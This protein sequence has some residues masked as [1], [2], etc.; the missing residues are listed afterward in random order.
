MEELSLSDTPIPE[1][2]KIRWPK[3]V[4]LLH[5]FEK[6]FA[7]NRPKSAIKNKESFE[8]DVLNLFFAETSKYDY[9]FDLQDCEGNEEL[10]KSRVAQILNKLLYPVDPIKPSQLHA[11]RISSA[12]TNVVFQ[13]TLD[14][15]PMWVPAVPRPPLI[16][17]VTTS[18]SFIPSSVLPENYILRVYGIGIDQVIDRNNEL[19]WLNVLGKLGI[20]ARVFGLFQNGRLEEYLCNRSL[21]KDD[22]RN[23]EI[24]SKIASRM[25]ELHKLVDFIPAEDRSLHTSVGTFRSNSTSPAIP[26]ALQKKTP[27]PE[28]WVNIDNWIS[29]ANSKMDQIR[30]LCGSNPDHLSLLDRFPDI[31][32]F[33]K[34]YRNLAECHHNYPVVLAH[35]DFQYGNILE[36][37]KTKELVAVDYEYAGYNYRGAEIANHFTEWMADYSSEVPHSLIDANFPTLEQRYHFYKSYIQTNDHLNQS[38]SELYPNYSHLG[39]K[40]GNATLEIK[41]EEMDKEVLFFVPIIHLQWGVWG[42]IQACIS[43]IDFNYLVYGIQRINRFL[44][45]SQKQF[46]I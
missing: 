43:S 30:E 39:G 13:I 8:N 1:K 15:P 34:K 12:L 28:I 26:P 38:I 16:E 2:K 9:F 36:L 40:K 29:L 31:S 42:L 23:P 4:E 25:C 7:Q 3:F 32:V 6:N 33:I 14:Y 20:G 19:Y 21:N 24:S 5:N 45:F 27:Y 37:K 41:L 22:I 35:N 10:F 46:A 18:G 11:V 17:D 44:E